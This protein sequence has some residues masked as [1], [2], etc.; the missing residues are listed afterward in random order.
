MKSYI[1]NYRVAGRERR[2]TLAR[3]SELSLKA[4][5]ERAGEELAA[6]RAGETDLL[7]RRT[8][9]QQ[10]P[11]V[12]ESLTRFFDEFVPTRI[13]IGRM[14]ERTAREYRIQARGYVGP[15]LGKRRVADVTR[16]DIERMVKPLPNVTRN[17]VLA[18]VSR[19]FSLFETWE[20]RPQNT[21]PG[22]RH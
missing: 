5:R 14:T 8:Q 10:A 1:L 4:A 19:L 17:R 11:T 15:A 2:A 6:I 16:S 13:A 18:F 3:V 7:E 9:M 21:N 12:A 20:W 22:T